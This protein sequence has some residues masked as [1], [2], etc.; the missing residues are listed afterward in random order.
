MPLAV[1]EGGIEVVERDALPGLDRR[2]D[3]LADVQIALSVDPTGDRHH[4][5]R[6]LGCVCCCIGEVGGLA[7]VIAVLG[8]LTVGEDTFD[9]HRGGKRVRPVGAIGCP[10]HHDAHRLVPRRQLGFIGGR[11]PKGVASLNSGLPIQRG[12]S[13]RQ[14]PRDRAGRFKVGGFRPEHGGRFVTPLHRQVGVKAA[15]VHMAGSGKQHQITIGDPLVQRLATGIRIRCVVGVGISTVLTSASRN[16][17]DRV[18]GTV[19]YVEPDGMGGAHG[20]WR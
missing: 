10:D 20:G 11:N 6:G 19:L 12:G 14:V 17:E 18:A 2:D 7:A 4:G 9:I 13:H 16:V 5:Q 8:Q 3:V 1:V 15:R